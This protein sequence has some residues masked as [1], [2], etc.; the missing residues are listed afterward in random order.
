MKPHPNALITPDH[1]NLSRSYPGKTTASPGIWEKV[2][3]SRMATDTM[4]A[5]GGNGALIPAQ[6]TME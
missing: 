3:A 1:L 6:T 5:C 4:S 2:A